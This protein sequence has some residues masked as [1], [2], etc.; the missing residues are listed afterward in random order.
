MGDSVSQEADN[1]GTYDAIQT[2]CIDC[3]NKWI[4]CL[5]ALRA[6]NSDDSN[7]INNYNDI[8][9]SASDATYYVKPKLLGLMSGVFV[10]VDATGK[11]EC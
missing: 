7:Y 4:D 1:L 8:T 3:Y 11:T 2:I 10:N 5:R 6:D 9:V